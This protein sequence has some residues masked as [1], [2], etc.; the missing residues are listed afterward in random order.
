MSKEYTP[1]EMLQRL[2]T[3][4]KTLGYKVERYSKKFLPARVPLY[5]EKEKDKTD[6]IIVEITTDR[7]ISKD[8]FFPSIEI[9]HVVIPEASPVRFYQYYFPKAKICYAYPDNVEENTGFD[10]FK[11]VCEKRGIGLLKVSET[12]VEVLLE[13]CPLFNK[14]CNTLLEDKTKPEEIKNVISDLL[15]SYLHFLVYYPDPVYRRSEIMERGI[16]E[17][18]YKSSYRRIPYSISLNLL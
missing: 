11:K 16:P 2:E 8:D 9:D 7:V 13:S 3:H 1:E 18:I 6:E 14:I 4:F 15:D 5:C 12:G 17:L 10:D